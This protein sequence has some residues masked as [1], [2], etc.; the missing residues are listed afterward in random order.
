MNTEKAVS[1]L[2][3]GIPIDYYVTMD[4]D[5]IST[6]NDALGG[7][8]VTLEDDFSQID[9]EMVKGTT[10]CLQ[11]KQ[12]EILS[13]TAAMCQMAQTPCECG[14]SGFIWILLLLYC[15]NACHRI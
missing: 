2:F 13:G 1:D 7:V 8:T 5:G 11:G 3:A 4:L 14:V 10:I 6:F 12:A 9:P 15:W